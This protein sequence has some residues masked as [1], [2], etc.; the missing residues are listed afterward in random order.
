[1]NHVILHSFIIFLQML[2]NF[3]NSFTAELSKKFATLLIE[4]YP[5]YLKISK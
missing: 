3:K 4:Y 2:G 5:P 1:M